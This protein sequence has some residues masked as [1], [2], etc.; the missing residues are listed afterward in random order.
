MPASRPFGRILSMG[1][2]K[3]PIVK[4]QSPSTKTSHLHVRACVRACV[5]VRVR[6]LFG[7]RARQRA[8]P[9]QQVAPPQ[10]LKAADGSTSDR[11]CSTSDRGCSTSDRGCS[12]SDS[13]RLCLC[14]RVFAFRDWPAPH[15][16][17]GSLDCVRG[18]TPSPYSAARGRCQRWTRVGS[19]C[20]RAQKSIG[21]SGALRLW[22][23]PRTGQPS[24][25]HKRVG[26][27]VGP[28]GPFVA[29]WAPWD[30]F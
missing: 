2:P 22:P 18:V 9:S 10:S 30:F 26:V 13:C 25:T 21:I 27:F 19:I 3:A 4:R 23:P 15:M 5:C 17:H 29:P 14:R 8:E 12:T 1:H 28:H 16:R 24:G 7:R 20:R 6:V 11:G